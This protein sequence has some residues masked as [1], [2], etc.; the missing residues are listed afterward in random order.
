MFFRTS[1][2]EIAQNLSKDYPEGITEDE[3]LNIIN[4]VL[5]RIGDRLKDLFPNSKPS[6]LDGWN[7][8]KEESEK[9]FE[10]LLSKYDM[11]KI[12]YVA[13]KFRNNKTIGTTIIEKGLK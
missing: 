4:D 8:I 9:L 7:V 11:L 10:P 3:V 13:S 1:L 12:L 5:P 2:K 6:V